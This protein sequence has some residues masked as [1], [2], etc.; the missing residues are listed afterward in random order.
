MNNELS[1]YL[2]N[3]THEVC[4]RANSSLK[5]FMVGFFTVN[6]GGNR[7]ISFKGLKAFTTEKTIGISMNKARR[8]TTAN[9]NISPA[10]ERFSL[11][12]LICFCI[13]KRTRIP[14]SPLSP[15]KKFTL[16]RFLKIAV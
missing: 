12:F 14:L 5:L 11:F 3:G 15:E 2:E 13:F 6:L 7:N 16:Q 4:K 10:K 1:R 8:P 9:S